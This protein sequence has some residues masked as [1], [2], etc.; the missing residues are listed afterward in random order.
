MFIRMQITFQIL[1]HILAFKEVTKG[2]E[3]IELWLFLLWSLDAFIITCF[4]LHM[5]FYFTKT[6]QTEMLLGFHCSKTLF[7]AL[8]K[9]FILFQVIRENLVVLPVTLFMFAD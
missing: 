8:E 1:Y 7:K 9:E 6:I 2:G 4:Q 5:T 3:V